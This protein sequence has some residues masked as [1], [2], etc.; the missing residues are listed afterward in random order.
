MYVCNIIT[1]L[2]IC[3]CIWYSICIV[4]YVKLQGLTVQTSTV[5]SVRWRNRQENSKTENERTLTT[6]THIHITKIGICACIYLLWYIL[7]NLFFYSD[8]TL[9]QKACLYRSEGLSCY[10]TRTPQPWCTAYQPSHFAAF[11]YINI[12][13][14]IWCLFLSL[15]PYRYHGSFSIPFYAHLP[16]LWLVSNGSYYAGLSIFHQ[17]QECYHSWSPPSC[18]RRLFVCFRARSLPRYAHLF[19]WDFQNSWQSRPIAY[20]S[21]LAHYHRGRCHNCTD[22]IREFANAQVEFGVRPIW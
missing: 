11:Y 10:T 6:Q 19:A 16:R 12:S 5:E 20:Y 22:G 13:Q 1:V 4:I 15:L 14:H 18:P 7:R 17:E 3:I 9:R 21:F 2:T 8:L